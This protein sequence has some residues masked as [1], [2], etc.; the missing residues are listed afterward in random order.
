MNKSTSPQSTGKN[1]MDYD[2]E[3]YAVLE[4]DYL[5]LVDMKIEKSVLNDE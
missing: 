3:Y 1:I 4:E 2:R 5:K